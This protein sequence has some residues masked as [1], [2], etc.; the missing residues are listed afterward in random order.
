[1]RFNTFP[2]RTGSD[3]AKAAMAT[4]IK[5]GEPQSASCSDNMLSGL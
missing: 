5:P 1:M 4:N 2:S 3:P